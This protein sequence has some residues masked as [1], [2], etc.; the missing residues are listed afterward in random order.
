VPINGIAVLLLAMTHYSLDHD[1]HS[2][3][4]LS[5][6]TPGPPETIMEINNAKRRHSTI[7]YMSPMEFEKLLGLALALLWWGRAR[8][9][10][11]HHYP[12]SPS[13]I[14]KNWERPPA[15][16]KLSLLA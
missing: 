7:G 12:Y 4:S 14:I 2:K 1:K 9:G 5:K 3:I 16:T 8:I 15:H 11:R 10:S 13:D 6:G